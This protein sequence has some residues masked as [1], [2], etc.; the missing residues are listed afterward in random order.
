[1]TELDSQIGALDLATSLLADLFDKLSHC[2]PPAAAKNGLQCF[3]L[4]RSRHG[5]FLNG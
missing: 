2:V 4:I 5:F 3:L 1:M